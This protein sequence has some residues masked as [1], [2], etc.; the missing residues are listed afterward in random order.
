MSDWTFP[1]ASSERRPDVACP[2]CGVSPYIGTQWVC[3][4]DGCGG[5]F[6]TFQTR[7]R[8][9]HCSAQFAWT[10]CPACHKAS[11][12]KA[13]YRGAAPSSGTGD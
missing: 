9:P 3:A 8:C 1:I 6:D 11:S 12:H 13:W 7:A 4:P 5:T 10:A 2:A